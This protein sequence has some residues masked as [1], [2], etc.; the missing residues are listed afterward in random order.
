MIR[1]RT[2][3][4]AW[5]NREKCRCGRTT[6]RINVVGRKDDMFIVS[7][8]NVFP[9]DVEFVIRGLKGTTG[10]YRIRV[11]EKDY[12]TKYKVEVEKAEDNRQSDE[13]F[14]QEITVALKARCGV[15]PAEVV[16]LEDGALPRATHKAKRVF[17]ERS[18]CA[19]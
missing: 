3:D 7:G 14:R 16:V 5:I 15:K 13:E 8:V 10:E 11:F 4:I 6:A 19:L 18:R 9:S 1:F 17:D 12:T 2:G